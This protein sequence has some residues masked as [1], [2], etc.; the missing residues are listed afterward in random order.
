MKSTKKTN[1]ARILDRMGIGYELKEYPVDVN[2]LSAV[3]VAA[4]VGMPV[5]QVFKTLVAR[6]DKTG[7]LMACIPGDGELDLKALAAASGNK[8]TEMVHLKEVLGLTGYIR[9]GC[10]PLGAKKEY[11]VYLDKSAENW[12]IIAI[13]AGKRGEQIMLAPADLIQAVHAVV[14]KI[15]K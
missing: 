9:G 13:S 3:N 7:V 10:S 4:K 2:D 12:E 5:Q 15:A 6:G 11:P 14:T 8:K 1:A